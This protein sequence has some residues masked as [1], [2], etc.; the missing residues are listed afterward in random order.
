[1]CTGFSIE[2]VRARI[3]TIFTCVDICH[4]GSKRAMGEASMVVEKSKRSTL[5][6]KIIMVAKQTILLTL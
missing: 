5:Q 3:L 4:V 6:A 2:A 1:M